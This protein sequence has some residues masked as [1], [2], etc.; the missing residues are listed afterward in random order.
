MLRTNTK[1]FLMLRFRNV[2]LGIALVLAVG[3]AAEA[4]DAKSSITTI[5]INGE[6]CSACVKKL[7]VSLAEVDGIASIEGDVE[8]KTMTIK[9]KA[10]KTLSP[11]ELWE[12]VE[13]AGKKP[14]KLTGPNGTFEAKPKN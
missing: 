3:A 12:A 10:R 4:A 5:T 1:E 2:C 13:R 11:K 9:P 6:M 14:G 7:K 8:T